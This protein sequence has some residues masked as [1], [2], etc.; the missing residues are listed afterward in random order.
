MNQP[1]AK[2][3]EEAREISGA[4]V[5]TRSIGKRKSATK[6]LPF[7]CRD[8]GGRWRLKADAE[9]CCKVIQCNRKPDCPARS[10][11]GDCG[12]LPHSNVAMRV[13]GLADDCACQGGWVCPS[14]ANILRR[15]D[16]TNSTAALSSRDT[17]IREVLEGLRGL[18]GSRNCWCDAD[19]DDDH[20][21]ACLAAR[22][23]WDRLQ[24]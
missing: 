5:R 6:R 11:Y 16:A 17:E 7:A 15:R 20:Y 21:L 13:S 4:V 24:S 18:Q 10:H 23:L 8:C 3:R 2:H 1:T 12:S 22:G 14:C 19:A 9:E